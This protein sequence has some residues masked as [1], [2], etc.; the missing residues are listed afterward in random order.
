MHSSFFYLLQYL[1]SG[2]RV[3]FFHSLI[4][5]LSHLDFSVLRFFSPSPSCICFHFPLLRL[6]LL[7]LCLMLCLLLNLLPVIYFITPS[8]SLHLLLPPT[9][10]PQPPPQHIIGT[11]SLLNISLAPLSLS[12]FLAFFLLHTVT[13]LNLFPFLDP[14]RSL[15]PAPPTLGSPS[16]SL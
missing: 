3:T 16:C 5:L 15:F 8:A 6:P 1:F 13:S 4:T 2:P 14:S 11:I 7:L 9:P 10:L 12:L